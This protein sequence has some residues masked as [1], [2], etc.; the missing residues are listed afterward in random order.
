MQPAYNDQRWISHFTYVYTAMDFVHTHSKKSQVTEIIKEFVNMASTRFGKKIR[1]FRS[2]GEKAL[3][4]HFRALVA[5]LGITPEP[6]SPCTSAQNRAAERSGG[7]ILMKAR[8]LKIEVT[9]RAD[10]WSEIVSAVGYLNNR[11][12]K[13][14]LE[15]EDAY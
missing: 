6:S 7:V 10:L 11:T 1:Y 3:G 13:R 5:D 2:D 15:L 12:P 14:Q 8:C 4:N 9:L